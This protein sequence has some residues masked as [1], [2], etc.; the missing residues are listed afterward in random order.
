MVDETSPPVRR[1]RHVGLYVLG[2]IVVAVIAV[3]A[4]W[5]WDWFLPIVDAKASAALGRTVTAQHMHVHL[6]RT[7]IVALDNVQ[8]ANADG[9]PGDKP[10]AQIG[11]LTVAADVMAYI[12]TRQIVLP[13]IVVDNPVVEADQ[14]ASGK[15]NWTLATG[16]GGTGNASDSGPKIGQLVINHGRA[17]VA[18]AKL[19]A[20][21]NLDIATR[22]P[23]EVSGA[24]QRKAAANAGEIVVGAKGTYAGQPIEGQFVGGALLSLRDESNPY[25]VNLKLANGP[26]RVSLV[27][28]VQDPLHLAGANLRLEFT[29]PDMSKLTPLTGVPIPETPSYLIAGRLDYAD[30][31]VRFTGFTGRLGSS[32]LNGDISIDPTQARPFVDANLYSRQ[33]DLPDLGGFIGSAPGRASTPGQSAQQRAEV[34]RAEASRKLIPDTPINLPKLNAANVRLRYKG[35]RIEGRSVPFDNIVVALDITDGRIQLHPVSFA[36]GSGTILLNAD[37]Q[38]AGRDLRTKAEIEFRRLDLNRML[39]ATHMVNG[40]G[41]VSGAAQIESTGNSLSTLLGNGNGGVRLGMAGGNLS[42][43]LVDLSGLEFGNA[44]LSALGIPQTAQI[45]C[46]VGEFALQRGVVSTRTLLLDTSEARIQGQGGVNLSAETISYRLQTDAR[47]FSIGSLKTPIDITG[48]LKS[49]SIA[50]EAGPLALRGGLAAGLGVLF[51]PAALI[52]TIQF[53]IGEDNACQAAAP[54]ARAVRAKPASPMRSRVAH[55]R[56]TVRR[57]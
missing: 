40:G 2:G 28:T 37:L 4:L 20:D 11:K 33:V 57:R 19:R 8:V 32:D 52:P 7:T 56:P 49:P 12:H 36:V 30:K 39:A 21:M 15:A 47:H 3:V 41:T 18:I 26:T 25:P 29:G 6:G 9:F 50:P 35:A 46:F 38:P 5:D 24:E 16:S 51:P 10:F 53:G 13:Q 22:Q 23:Q 48:S 54:L 42:A 1:R 17:H 44:L 31:K 43:L 27:G 34:A 45:R 14:D 55:R